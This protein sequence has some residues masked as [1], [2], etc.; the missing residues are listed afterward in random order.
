MIM[1]VQPPAASS[2]RRALLWIFAV[3]LLLRLIAIPV[4]ELLQL[5]GHVSHRFVNIAVNILNGHGYADAPGVPN[6]FD[7]PVYQY[8]LAALFGLFGEGLTTVKVFQAALD[9]VTACIVCLLA[10]RLFASARVGVV[11]GL[12]YAVFPL[13]IYSV[14]DVAPETLF[15]LLLSLTAFALVH[16]MQTTKR[17]YFVLAGVLLGVATLTRPTTLYLLPFLIVPLALLRSTRRT[18]FH[19][20]VLTLPSFALAIAPWTIRNYVVTGNV[21]PV[22]VGGPGE[23]L[24][25]GSSADFFTIDGK[26]RNY[27]PYFERL[28]AKGI[29]LPPN[30]TDM[31]WDRFTFLAAREMYAERWRT[32]GPVGLGAFF[33]H[34][35]GRLWYATESGA[36][37]KLI[38]LFTVP[39][40]LLA[41]VGM[42]TSWRTG[43]ARAEQLPLF[44]ILLY[45]VLLHWV[46]L[47]LV[48]Y[49]TPVFPLLIVHAGYWLAARLPA[50]AFAFDPKPP[51]LRSA[52]VVET[53]R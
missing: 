31:E 12:L 5:G 18:A 17:S 29:V 49:M 34:K 28:K 1:S 4:E 20:A 45:F 41:V 47:P 25:Q 51:E 7:A 6:V 38:A 11:A 15:T 30:H 27:Y 39:F 36:H 32:E 13:A 21:V 19:L 2:M 50:R 35:F 23:V 52:P 44:G 40:L 46:T 9:S 16:A 22:A 33:L 8:V 43:A 42:F 14:A 10:V 37:H 24:L 26:N 48:R 3:A 53:S